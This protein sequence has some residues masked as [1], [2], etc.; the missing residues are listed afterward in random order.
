MLRKLPEIKSGLN[1]QSLDAINLAIAGKVLPS[2]QSVFEVH[3]GDEN[4]AAV[5]RSDWLQRNV[6]AETSRKASVDF[7]ES[8]FV[9]NTHAG[10]R[11]DSANSSQIKN[12]E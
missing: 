1:S 12:K 8:Y 10:H 6:E 11:R 4:V 7:L 5:L 9:Q 2:F 3:N